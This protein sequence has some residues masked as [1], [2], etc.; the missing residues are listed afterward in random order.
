MRLNKKAQY[1]LLL[2]LYLSRSGRASIDGVAESLKLSRGFLLQ[3]ARTLRQAGVLRS[4]RGPHGGYELVPGTTVLG[5]L[6]AVGGI[7]PLNYEERRR[8]ERGTSEHRA[9]ALLSSRMALALLSVC[10]QPVGRLAIDLATKELELLSRA[11]A[12]TEKGSGQ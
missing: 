7:A 8:C 5:V 1:A 6:G 11:T 10:T 9:L 2:A 3:V 4:H 12:V